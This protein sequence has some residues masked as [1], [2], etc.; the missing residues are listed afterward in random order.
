[1]IAL[2][3]KPMDIST[4]SYHKSVTFADY[5]FS[6]ADQDT[7]SNSGDPPQLYGTNRSTTEPDG[8][9][10]TFSAGFAFLGGGSIE[11]G[12]VTDRQGGKIRVKI[13][14]VNI[15]FGLGAGYSSKGIYVTPSDP[16]GV[17]TVNDFLNSYT[18]EIEGG[19][20][21][22]DISKGWHANEDLMTPSRPYFEIQG[23]GLTIGLELGVW[24]TRS[25]RTSQW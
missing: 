13:V 23:G 22:F 17:F 14:N 10:N 11:Y 20:F 24:W 3:S 4:P 25:V 12:T 9:L 19:F 1:M 18:H 16:D 15:G 21:I 5:Y 7:A 2:K 8:E 6:R